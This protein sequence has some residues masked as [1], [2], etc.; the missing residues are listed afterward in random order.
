MAGFGHAFSLFGERSIKRDFTEKLFPVGYYNYH[1][2][3]K[4][5]IQEGHLVR[6]EVMES[7]NGIK[8]ALVLFFDNHIP[9]PVREERWEEY[10]FLLHGGSENV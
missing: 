2:V 4:R 9:M 6:F 8:P 5:L 7:W 1:A 3:A 10:M